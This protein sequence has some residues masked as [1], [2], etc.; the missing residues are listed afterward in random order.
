MAVFSELRRKAFISKLMLHT[1]LRVCVCATACMWRSESDSQESVLSL[2][3]VHSSEETQMIFFSHKNLYSPTILPAH[4]GHLWTVSIIS[5]KDWKDEVHG[6]IC[7]PTPNF[8]SE[9]INILF[10]SP[11][12]LAGFTTKSYMETHILKNY[13]KLFWS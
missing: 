7:N 1:Y 10:F 8:L 9:L 12:S 3:F 13:F 11:T 4:K 6:S 5:S 2:H